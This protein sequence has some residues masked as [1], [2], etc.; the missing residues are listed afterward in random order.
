MSK[1]A[2]ALMAVMGL[3]LAGTALASS[4][5]F[6]VPQPEKQPISIRE[7]SARGNGANSGSRR[8]R[9]VFISGGIFHGK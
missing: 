8:Y 2:T 5:G 9:P 4:S 1:G 3:V 6:G 7:G